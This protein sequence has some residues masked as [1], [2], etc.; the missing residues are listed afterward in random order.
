MKRNRNAKCV[1]WL[2]V[3]MTSDNQR[4]GV[5]VVV[6]FAALASGLAEGLGEDAARYHDVTVAPLYLVLQFIV[7]AVRSAVCIDLLMS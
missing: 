1:H 3:R 6:D 2:T 7:G 5:V 4:L